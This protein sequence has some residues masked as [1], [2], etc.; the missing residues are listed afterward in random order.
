MEEWDEIYQR[1][2][3]RFAEDAASRL[4]AI[5]ALVESVERGDASESTLNAIHTKFHSLAGCAGSYG[6]DSVSRISLEAEIICRNA[7]DANRVAARGE[8]ARWRE[9]LAALERELDIARQEL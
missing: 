6:Y 4:E 2:R 7:L 9:L 3:V 8:V 5:S 1:I